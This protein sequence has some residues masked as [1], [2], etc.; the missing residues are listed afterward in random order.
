MKKR[1]LMTATLCLVASL[2]SLP[3]TATPSLGQGAKFAKVSL[4]KVYTSSARLKAAVDEVNKIRTETAGKLAIIQTQMKTIQ[5]QLQKD[6]AKLK[7]EEK[8]KLT[9]E[10]QA[11][12]KQIETEQQNLRVKIGFKQKSVQNVLK[13]QLPDLVNKIGKQEGLTAI[14]W[15]GSL[16][17][18]AGIPDISAKVAKALD[19]LP[20]LEQ[21]PPENRPVQKKP[22]A[23]PTNTK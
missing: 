23:K 8:K 16:A 22:Q 19:A 15:H 1:L 18:S 2:V 7:P 21:G 10:L 13:T 4:E 9:E 20:P 17:Y 11:K 14:F 12:V 6:A 3:L 5:G